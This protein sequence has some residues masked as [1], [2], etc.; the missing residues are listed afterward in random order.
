MSSYKNKGVIYCIR[1]FDTDSIYIGQTIQNPN[2][3]KNKHFLDLRKNIHVNYTLQND[4][5][6]Y[7]EDSFEFYIIG[8][9][10]KSVLD[11]EEVKLIKVF[12][13]IM[14]V[15]NIDITNKVKRSYSERKYYDNQYNDH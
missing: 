11:R 6:L 2:T 14:T 15:Y 7:G 10:N 3:R 8:E 5:N 9:Y 12:S 4:Y 13:N 1:C